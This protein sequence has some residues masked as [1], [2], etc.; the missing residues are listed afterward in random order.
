MING[1]PSCSCRILVDSLEVMADI[2]ALASESGVPQPLV[3]HIA[4]DVVPPGGDALTQTIDYG[5]VRR[6]ALD[7]AAE[8][9][10]LIE[11]FARRLAERCLAHDAVL[12]AEVRIAKPLALPD[13]LAGACVTL[14]KPRG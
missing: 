3:L 11:T 8:R 2:G 6:S 5:D 9:T 10:V 1:P 7:L 14:T 4:L 12:A 13:C